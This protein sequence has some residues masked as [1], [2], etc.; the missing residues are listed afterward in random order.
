MKPSAEL[1]ELAQRELDRLCAAF[2]LGYRPSLEWRSFR[3]T[4]GMAYYRRRAI[5]LGAS[6]LTTPERLR[7]TLVHEYA[8][9][10]AFRRYGQAGRG[11]SGP[12][13]QA[14]LDLG[15]EPRVRHTYE[16][17][18]NAHRQRV[19]Y[20]CVRCGTSIER[21]RRLPKS[22]IYVHANCGGGLKLEAIVREE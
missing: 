17:A 22:N 12:W 11:H 20:R 14:M 8:H 21:R 4:A 1:A 19:T 2:P 5:G 18:R 13:R 16:V 3:T 10:L 6:V 9:L 15:A 7:D